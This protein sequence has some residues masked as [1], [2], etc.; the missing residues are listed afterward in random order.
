MLGPLLGYEWDDETKTSYYT[1]IVRLAG[2][3]G[4]PSWELSGRSV[5]MTRIAGPLH[6]GSSIWRGEAALEPF[7]APSG[8]MVPYRILLAGKPLAN[9]CKDAKWEFHLPGKPTATRQPR[10]AF[11][12]CNGFSDP[13]AAEKMDPLALWKHFS[14]LHGGGRQSEP[15]S[16]L[17]MGGDQLYCDNIAR[18]EDSGFSLWN[19]MEPGARKKQVPSPAEFL[20]RYVDHYLLAWS[21]PASH[22]HVAMIRMMASVP[23]VMI[24][25]DHDIHDGW[26]SYVAD[27]SDRPYYTQAFAAARQSFEWYQA[28]GSMN[29]S[30]IDKPPAGKPLRHFSQG[31]KFGPYSIITLDNRSNRTPDQIMGKQQWEQVISWADRHADPAQTLLVV[32]PIPVVYR[33]FANWLTELPGE[34]GGEDDLRDHWNHKDHEGERNKLVFHLFEWRAAYRRVTLLSGDVHVGC[35]GFLENTVTGSE[36]AQIVSSAIVHPAP[37]AVQW[38]GVCAVSTA[39]DFTIRAQPV[40]ATMTRPQGSPEMFL[41]CRNFTWFYQGDDS[42]LWINWEC[43]HEK[44]GMK[45]I[46]TPIR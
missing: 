35:M 6:D 19:W 16:L 44:S 13:K 32:S 2:G 36:V 40:V 37:S 42:K 4:T 20:R 29:R 24:W 43:E 30:M 21:G 28:R 11:C 15:F 17:L 10:I 45:Q 18:Q 25:D 12:S 14:S 9:V 3:A 33:R 38:V 8:A 23:S 46:T 5:T 27:P 41:R 7:T 34:H 1:V 22:P 31:L 39:D 26:G